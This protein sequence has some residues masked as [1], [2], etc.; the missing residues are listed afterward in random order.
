MAGDYPPERSE[1]FRNHNSS[2]GAAPPLPYAPPERSSSSNKTVGCWIAGCL[3]SLFLGMLLIAAMGFGGYWFLTQQVEKY[4]DAEPAPM[5]PVEMEAEEIAELQKSFNDFFN[6]A[7]PESGEN[8]SAVATDGE[9]LPLPN[10][11]VLTADQINALLQSNETFA[12]RA[13][14]EI[15][16]GI[17]LAKV[18]IPTDQVPGGAGRHFNADAEV[19]VSLQ[20]GVLLIQIVDAKVKGES[21]PEEFSA[22]LS[23]QNLAKELYEDPNTAKMLQR[24]ESV[25][26]LDNTIR[27]R[28]K[29]KEKPPTAKAAE[30]ASPPQPMVDDPFEA[31]EQRSAETE[32]LAEPADQSELLEPA[33]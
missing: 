1:D 16:E 8:G 26:V 24:F 4:T 6:Q 15:K 33:Q 29:P 11:L 5:P 2:R 28:L 17:I 20:N 25:E 32:P 9:E 13:Y 27:M 3:G 18:T 7:M 21:L 22:E 31:I 10:E 14:V 19:D 12:D 30:K 23:K